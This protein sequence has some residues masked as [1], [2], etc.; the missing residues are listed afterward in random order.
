MASKD[1]FKKLRD[2]FMDTASESDV[3]VY[4]RLMELDMVSAATVFMYKVIKKNERD[5]Q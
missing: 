1:F 4:C 2:L 5:L 3:V